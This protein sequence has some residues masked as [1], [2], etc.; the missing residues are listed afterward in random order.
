MFSLPQQF[1]L[2]KRRGHEIY[3]ELEFYEV[4]ILKPLA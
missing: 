3:S 4:T 2:T 1:A